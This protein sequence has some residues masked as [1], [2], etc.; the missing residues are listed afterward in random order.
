MYVVGADGC[1]AGWVTFCL[2]DDN[3][4]EPRVFTDA[5]ALLHAYSDADLILMDVPIGLR[6]KGVEERCC[7][8]WARQ[9]LGP[10]R[11]AGVFPVPCRS[12]V[13]K[14]TYEVASMCNHNLTG[15]R[16]SKQSWAIVPK[17][18]EVDRLLADKTAFR[19]VIRE[20]HPEVCFWALAGGHPMKYSKKKEEGFQERIEILKKTLRA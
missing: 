8:K 16:L 18:R 1:R 14:E 12:A 15:R 10:P 17:I 2:K 4:W 6:E 7:D 9:V 5:S 20:V 11:A 3:K 19:R 13:Y